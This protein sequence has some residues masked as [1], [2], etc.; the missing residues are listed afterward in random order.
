[1]KKAIL[2]TLLAAGMTV[3]MASGT[4]AQE[5]EGGM[6]S[7]MMQGDMRLK[8]GGSIYVMLSSDSDLDLLG[9]LIN[10]AGL[11][12]RLVYERS[13]YIESMILYDLRPPAQ[14]AVTL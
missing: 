12:A 1:M 14:H 10:K 3:T 9:R 8:P 2:I 6:G 5:R 4:V 7:G 11:R 13:F